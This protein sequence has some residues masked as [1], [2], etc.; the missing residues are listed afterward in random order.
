MP[1]GGEL[2]IA[3]SCNSKTDEYISIKIADNGTGIP[4]GA[5]D[6]IF[7][8]FFTTKEGGTGLGLCIVYRVIQ[9]HNG[10]IQINSNFGYGTTAT[11][12]LPTNR[13]QGNI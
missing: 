10:S 9:A 7:I 5:M 1:E 6:R 11:I 12:Q 3:A 2:R 4:N 13:S 8:P